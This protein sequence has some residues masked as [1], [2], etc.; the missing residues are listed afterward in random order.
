MSSRLLGFSAFPLH[1]SLFGLTD[2]NVIEKGVGHVHA[3]FT[4]LEP[5]GV[6]EAVGMLNDEMLGRPLRRET[7]YQGWRIGEPYSPDPVRALVLA[8]RLL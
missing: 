5:E 4:E 7:A 8:S 3:A 1:A 2:D 6:E